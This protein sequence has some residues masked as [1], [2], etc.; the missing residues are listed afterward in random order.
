MALS[1]TLTYASETEPLSE[2]SGPVVRLSA[3]TVQVLKEA[4]KDYTQLEVTAIVDDSLTVT[5]YV[6][7]HYKIRFNIFPAHWSMA[8]ISLSCDNGGVF[9]KSFITS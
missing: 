9:E 2:T 6:N 1:L 3:E 5:G 4:G 8:L 7:D